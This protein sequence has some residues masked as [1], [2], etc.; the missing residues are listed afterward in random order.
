M[1]WI[2]RSD[3]AQNGTSA[4]LPIADIKRK[5]YEVRKVPTPEVSELFDH[6]VSATEQRERHGDAEGLRG[7]QIDDQFDSGGPLHR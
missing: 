3:G 5:D 2:S 6:L 7:F 4:P 1:E